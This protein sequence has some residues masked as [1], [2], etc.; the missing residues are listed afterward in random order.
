[1]DRGAER[2]DQLIRTLLVEDNPGDARL[3]REMMQETLNGRHLLTTV[4]RL[5]EGLLF[6]SENEADVVLLDLSLP[7]SQGMETLERVAKRAPQVPIVVLTGHNDEEMSLQTLRHGAQDYLVKGQID[8]HILQRTL[9]HAIERK[10]LVAEVE[11]QKRQVL[12]REALLGEI[13]ERNADGLIIVDQ[14]G[15]IRFANPAAEAIFGRPAQDLVGTSFRF[16]FADNTAQELHIPLPNQNTVVVEMRPAAI[17][18]HEQP[19]HLVSLRDI[20]QR[21]SME[22]DLENKVGMLSVLAAGAQKMSESLV[23]ADL[24]GSMARTCVDGFGLAAAWVVQTDARQ[25]FRTLALYPAGTGSVEAFTRSES[26]RQEEN[27]PILRALQQCSQV[28]CDSA[29]PTA[30][31]RHCGYC[32]WPD[33]ARSVTCLPLV[34]QGKTFGLLVLYSENGSFFSD[35]IVAFFQSYAHLA[36]GAL[37]KAHLFS[38]KEKH[39]QQLTAL[40]DID[41]AITGS[42]DLQGNLGVLLDN[43]L[44]LLPIDAAAVLLLNPHTQTL[45]YVTGRGFRTR[46]LQHTSLRLGEGHAGQAALERRRVVLSELDN[47]Q[48]QFSAS[49]HLGQE[50][51]QAY[52]GIP[53]VTKGRIRGVLEVFCRTPFDGAPGWQGLLDSLASQAAI[54]IDNATLYTDLEKANT[55]LYLA[56]EE[57][58]E[59]W[60]HALDY[61]DRETEGH[62][63]RVTEMTVRTA[64]AFG[65]P[66]NRLPH[67]RRGA[68]LHDIG[69]LGVP[70]NILF[71]PDKLTE[72]EWAIMRRH[73]ELAYSLLAPISFLRPALDIPYCHH[74]RWD[75][76]GYPRGLKGEEIPVEARIFAVVDVWDALSSDRPYRPAWP[77]EKTL[78]Y[79]T[80]QAG[81]HFDPRVVEVFLRQVI[82]DDTK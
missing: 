53:L 21:K 38:E 44:T 16:P 33:N 76:S 8:G 13:I 32:P 25:P 78:T 56:Y 55:E 4:E 73:P 27:C 71:K 69:K 75:G 37:E 58:L 64:R 66:E 19:A 12:D 39:L 3:I 36:S 18:W 34:S 68:L 26:L 17:F 67:V 23:V 51:F 1:M 41:H 35:E 62:S 15:E 5:A 82:T 48:T 54:A 10:Q 29:Q 43:A 81:R 79:L 45:E 80:E 47:T 60:A 70:D 14:A 11:E 52:I 2:T 49:P 40:R 22:E 72:A 6:L 24:A 46:A 42:F 50:G 30:T 28:T 20:T 9:R 63:R 65:I 77:A 61:R 57:T 31:H 74:E 7:D 59:G